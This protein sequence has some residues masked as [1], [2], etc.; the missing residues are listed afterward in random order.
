MA[1]STKDKSYGDW[2][3][4]VNERL[5]G[6]YCITIEDAGFDEGYLFRHW[7]SN[8]MP[9]EFVEWFGNKYDLEPIGSLVRSHNRDK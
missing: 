1:V 4:E 6:I 3:D 5:Q 8:E 7:Q 2:R 9:H